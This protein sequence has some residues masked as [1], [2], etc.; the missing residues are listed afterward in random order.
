MS[1]RDWILGIIVSLGGAATAIAAAGSAAADSRRAHI[2]HTLLPTV[3]EVG[4]FYATPQLHDGRRLRLLVDTGGTGGSG[5]WVID[6]IAAERLGFRV[7]KC[8]WGDSSFDVIKTVEYRPGKGLPPSP[9]TP[10]DSSTLLVKGVATQ[11]DHADGMLGAGY[12]PGHIWTFDYPQKQLWLEPPSWRADAGMHQVKLGFMRN[13]AGNKGSGMARIQIM[14]D[15]QP[16]DMLLDTGATAKPTAAGIEATRIETKHGI[17][18]ISYITSGVMDRWHRDHPNWRMVR[19]GDNIFGAHAA[20][21]LIEVPRLTIAGW[22][23]GPVWFTER[24]DATFHN[25]MSAYMDQPIEGVV[26]ANVFEHFVMTVNYPA[27]RAW[28]ACV[29]GCRSVGSD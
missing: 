29:K 17:G 8:A 1:R 20:T 10:C 15:G 27:D 24:S 26:G 22:Q 18:V 2:S 25:Y 12:L 9:Q 21:R 5:W 6:P 13:A 3:Y 11:L 4:H 28:F 23:V 19:D 16:L 7:S 14:V